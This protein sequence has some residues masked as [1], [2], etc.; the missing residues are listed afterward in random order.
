MLYGWLFVVVLTVAI[1]LPYVR[2]TSDLFNSRSLFLMGSI[3]FTG[4][5]TIQ[6]GMTL[7]LSGELLLIDCVRFIAAATIFYAS[8]EMAYHLWGY[9]RRVA[10]RRW[11]TWGSISTWP[12]FT[13]IAICIVLGLVVT[14]RID[15]PGIGVLIYDFCSKAPLFALVFACVAWYRQPLN[16]TMAWAAGIA[17]CS[18]GLS[19]MTAFSRQ[20]LLALALSL[21]ICVYW[22]VLRHR[23]AL[24]TLLLTAGM[25]FGGLLVISAYTSIRYAPLTAGTSK[26][27][28]AMAR[29]ASLPSLMLDQLMNMGG[30]QDTAGLQSVDTTEVALHSIAR[31]RDWS[32]VRPFFTVWYV[33]VNPIPREYWPEKPEALGTTLPRDVGALRHGYVNWGPGIV[34]HAYHEGGPL[35]MIFYGVLLGG[36]MRFFDDLLAR[37]PG[38]PYLLGILCVLS[39]QLLAYSRGDLGVFTVQMIATVVAGHVISRVSRLVFGQALAYAS[40]DQHPLVS[41]TQLAYDRID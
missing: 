29:V 35:I 18:A 3:Q 5:A 12:L 41:R 31:Y 28:E 24:M 25:A 37:Q 21:P 39:A 13:T 17:A 34:G 7:R 23:P 4:V 36:C 6:S 33:L 22:L 2:G 32:D 19:A 10:A 14:L 40:E 38:N 9:P 8:F 1:L 11:L 20:P 16:P 27:E 15:I 26:V 30:E